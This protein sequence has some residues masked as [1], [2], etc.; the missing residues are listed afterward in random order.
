MSSLMI[1]CYTPDRGRGTGITT[2]DGRI[3]PTPSPSF[4]IVHPRLPV[5]YAVGEETHGT[6]AAWSLDDWSPLG[7]GETGGADPCH[8]LV[9]GDSLVT[10]NYSGGSIAVH[11]LDADGRIG[12]RTDLVVHTRHGEHPRQDGP[13]PHMLS[14]TPDGFLVTD[15]GGDAIYHYHVED[16]RLF[17]DRIVEAPTG[18]GP[19]H[20]LRLGDRWMVT[21]E[22]SGEVLVYDADWTL[23]GR[24]AARGSTE[25]N[26]VSELAASADHLY[27]ANRGPDTVS[28]FSLGGDLPVYVTEVPVAANPRHIALDGDTLYI[29]SQDDDVVQVMRITDG[30]P[31]LVDTIATPSPTCVVVL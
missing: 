17:R 9:D 31:V 25:P 22:L 20:V 19:R 11:A 16:G 5:V 8:L 15:L 27:V 4:V 14:A 10:V 23:L 28:V 29:A 26:D 6:V 30:V 2:P 1:G 18:S 21:A 12:R 3:V 13:H 24:V 7:T